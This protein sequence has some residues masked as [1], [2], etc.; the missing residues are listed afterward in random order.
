M[1]L[2]KVP[3]YSP[4]ALASII[5]QARVFNIRAG[6]AAAEYN[7]RSDQILKDLQQ[8]FG[9]GTEREMAVLLKQAK[10]KD[11]ILETWGRR[12]EFFAREA[13]RLYATFEAELRYRD[14]RRAC[15]AE[16]MGILRGQTPRQRS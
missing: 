4:D 3:S 16:L 13:I 14:L 15:D 8:D 9:Y 1:G 6:E 12:Q 11:L 2:N 10:E 7:A 5:E